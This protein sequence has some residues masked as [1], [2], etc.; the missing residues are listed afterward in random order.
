MGGWLAFWPQM[1]IR[2]GM[3]QEVWAETEIGPTRRWVNRI[4]GTT[5]AAFLFVGFCMWVRWLHSGHSFLPIYFPCFITMQWSLYLSKSIG[6]PP[7]APKLYYSRF[8]DMKPIQSQHWG[9]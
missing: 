8:A 1:K 6:P 4:F 7:R 5:A 3:R 2:D 9:E